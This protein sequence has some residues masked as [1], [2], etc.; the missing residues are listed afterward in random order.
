MIEGLFTLPRDLLLEP[1]ETFPETILAQ[2][3]YMPGDFALTRPQSRTPTHIVNDSTAKL[4]EIFR[5]PVTIADA[6][7]RLS[8]T[9][10]M[11]P[12]VVLNEA[13]PIIK[14]LVEAG[15]LLPSDS[16][17]VSEIDF[18]FKP[19]DSIGG[20][21][22]N[23]S[24]AIVL[25]TEVYRART[26]NGTLAAVKIAR[27]GSEE[28]LRQVLADEA[29]ILTMLD[30]CCSPKLIAQGEHDG[31]PFLAMEWC[32]GVD[33]HTAAEL[34]RSRDSVQ[35]RE[36]KSIVLAIVD[37][38]AQLHE[39]HIVH[40]DVHPRNVLMCDSGK[41][42]LIDFGHARSLSDPTETQRRGRGMVDLYMEPELAHAL[43]ERSKTPLPNPASE[44]YSIAALLYFLLTGTH[45]HD[46]VLE[47][48]Q[49]RQQLAHDP[50]KSFEERGISG[51]VYTERTLA[52]ALRKNPESRF[53][54]V[55]QLRDAL[56]EAFDLDDEAQMTS[57]CSGRNRTLERN[58]QLEELIEQATFDGVLLRE[59]L[60]AP[61]ASINL[62]AAGLA[63]AMLRIAQQ[64]EDASL[65]AVA[66]VWSQV[67]LRDME[68]SASTAFTAPDLE[69]NPELVGKVSLYHSNP[70][71]ICVAALVADAQADEVRRKR[72][73]TQFVTAA[74]NDESRAELVF[75]LSGLL[76]GC[77]FLLDAVPSISEDE[78]TLIRSLGNDLQNKLLE[79]RHM[80]NVGESRT[81]GVAHGCAGV[82]YSLLQW[83][84]VSKV[85]ISNQ[86]CAYLEELAAYAQPVGRGLAWPVSTRV[87]MNWSRGMRATWCN[88][89][90]GHL[91]LWLL[92]YEVLNDPIYLS[93]ARSAAWTTYEAQSNAADLCCGSAG[94]AYALLRLF[95]QSSDR[96]WLHRAHEL[97]DHATHAIHTRQLRKNSLYRGELGVCLLT[98]ELCSPDRA[99]MPLFELAS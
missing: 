57:H 96:I 90:A 54:S 26:S 41:A 38:Y 10:E 68:S 11:D 1:V 55:G 83:A 6:V 33:V 82:F 78:Q 8:R 66:D 48:N 45:T 81:L 43:L 7:I 17:F 30:G 85:D 23:Q 42:A 18:L 71:V 16:H 15:M 20:L 14:V 73:I 35:K 56:R 39:R 52:K 25:D 47:K 61:S 50:H 32:M 53:P 29:R 92:A 63:Y 24:A 62:G 31:R 59:G 88:G 60:E 34:V 98:A 21:V 75:G 64:R 84:Q 80:K 13:F 46:F 44:Q 74:N 4:L 9:G 69:M 51:L 94:R 40:G 36:L 89:A 76:L 77:S 72:A 5:E 93:L 95:R 27:L 86:L 70:G 22:I 99:R 67:A 49:L 28:R 19:G 87:Q 12:R 79:Q 97:A 65:L 2:F 3:E 58:S 91:Q 37:A